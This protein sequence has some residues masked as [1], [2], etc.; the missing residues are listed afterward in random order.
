[1]SSVNTQAQVDVNN[2]SFWSELCGTRL[3][4]EVGVTDASP[5][6]LARFDRAYM[7]FYPYLERYLPWQVGRAGARDRARLRDRR[8]TAGAARP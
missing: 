5:E 7:D 1:M 2:A 8:A 6:S 4:R 3:A